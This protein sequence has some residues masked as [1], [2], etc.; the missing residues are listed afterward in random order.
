MKAPKCINDVQKL[1]GQV[2]TFE[3]FTSCSA[4]RC[5]LFFKALKGKNKFILGEECVEAFKN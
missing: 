2:T 4:K 5:L 3:G 1:N